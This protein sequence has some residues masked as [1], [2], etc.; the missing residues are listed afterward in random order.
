MY[1]IRNIMKI[2]VNLNLPPPGKQTQEWTPSSWP[3]SL[4]P[5][6]PPATVLPVD[7]RWAIR[8]SSRALQIHPAVSATSCS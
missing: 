6:R 7:H 2:E 3:A 5:H 4:R 1:F 8:G